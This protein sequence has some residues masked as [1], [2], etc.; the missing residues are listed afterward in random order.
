M[1]QNIHLPPYAP[2]LPQS[3]WELFPKLLKGLS[4]ALGGFCAS[5]GH[6]QDRRDSR[7]L[8]LT[9]LWLQ[10]GSISRFYFTG[11]F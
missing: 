3:G 2:V 1:I 7:T 9:A 5:A 6:S 10:L 11:T 4:P 8:F